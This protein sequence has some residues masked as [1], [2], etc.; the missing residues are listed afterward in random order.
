MPDKPKKD[1]LA[2]V[3]GQAEHGIYSWV[4][5]KKVPGERAFQAVRR[6]LE[7]KRERLIERHGGEDIT[8]EA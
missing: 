6:E 3:S 5:S 7:A 1:D 4:N 2:T 8:P